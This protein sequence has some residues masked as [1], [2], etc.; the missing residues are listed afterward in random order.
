MDLLTN[1]GYRSIFWSY[2]YADYDE[3]VYGNHYAFDKVTSNLHP[4]EVLL[5][6]AISADNANDL[7]DIIDY[8]QGQGYEFRTLDEYTW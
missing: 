6:H 3:I 4:G 5:L 7:A 2:A 8:V 1:M